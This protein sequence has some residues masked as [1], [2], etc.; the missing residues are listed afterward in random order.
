MEIYSFYTSL[1]YINLSKN[2]IEGISIQSILGALAI[3]FLIWLGF[4]VLQG[5]G[6]FAMAKKKGLK[7]PSLA[8]APFVNLLL[9]D[10]LAGDCEIFGHKMKRGGMYAMIAQIA[11]FVTGFAL[12]LAEGVLFTKYAGCINFNR[13]TGE[14]IWLDL[15]SLGVALYNFYSVWGSLLNSLFGLAYELLLFVLMIS[16][17]KRYAAKN[18][19]I[20]SMLQLFLPISRYVII[21]VVRN[22]KAVDYEEYKRAMYEEYRNR[23]AR[24]GNPYSNPYGNRYGNPYSNPYGNPYGTPYRGHNPSQGSTDSSQNENPFEEFA[25]PNED[26]F[27]D[28]N[29]YSSNAS[30]NPEP[31]Q[32]KSEDDFF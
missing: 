17:L 26:P 12:I 8:F 28:I 1:S 7:K 21:F 6:L 29:D 27:E 20:L 25:T 2:G 30:N 14:V 24:Y 4:F 10:K 11:V 32:D 9:I 3:S 19:M 18:Y 16:L 22:N 13:A 15:D 31:T 5:F 23:S